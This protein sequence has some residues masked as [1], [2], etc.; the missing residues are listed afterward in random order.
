MER[1]QFT[2]YRSY[3]EALRTLPAKDFKV[4]VLAICAY[5]LDEEVPSLSGVPNS[6]FTLIRPTLDSGRNKAANRL[7]KRKTNQEQTDNK[8]EQTRKE[9]EGE[10]EREE[11]SEREGENDM[12]K[13][14]PPG[15]GNTKSPAAAAGVSPLSSAVAMVQA[16]YLNRVNAAASP[17]SLD[18][19]AGFVEAMGP[20]CCRRA[21]DIALDERITRW[22][23]IRG[24]LQDKQQRGVKCLADWDA[25][26]NWRRERGG[27]GQRGQERKSWTD[28]CEEMEGAT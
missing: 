1:S 15:G 20:D 7:N 8:P 10:G 17:A 22:S 11:E 16:D 13:I 4:A 24:I 14:L 12:L 23:Y 3:Y 21:F 25:L 18:E 28:I 19:L 2:W 9:K 5:A 26:D 27:N 6:V